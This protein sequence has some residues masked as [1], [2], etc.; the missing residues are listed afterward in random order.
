MRTVLRQRISAY[1]GALPGTKQTT[2]QNERDNSFIDQ[3]Y[4]SPG[5]F[6][7]QIMQVTANVMIE[8]RA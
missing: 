5:I 1:S 3:A 6:P 8:K 2:A 4:M 7:L